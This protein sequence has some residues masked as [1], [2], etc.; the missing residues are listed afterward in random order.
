MSGPSHR[1]RPVPRRDVVPIRRA[2]ISVSDKTGLLELAAALAA[3]GVEI[4][5]TG[6][7]AKTIA[8]CRAS[9]SPRSATLTG[10]PE[11]LDGRVK[12]LHPAVHAG[13]LADLRL[14]SH[15]TEL[16]ELGHRAVRA[17]RVEPLPVRRRRSRR[18]P[19]R[20]RWSSRST[21]AAPRWCARA[22]KNHANVAIVTEPGALRATS[23]TRSPP[24]ARRSPSAARSRSRRSAHTATLRRRR[25][26]LAR[27]ASLAPDDEATGFPAWVGA[28]LDARRACCATARTRTSARRSTR[29]PHGG[30]HR[31]GD[32][33]RRQGDVV[34]QL[35]RC[36][37]GRARRLRPRDARRRDHQAREPVRHRDGATRSPR[38][39]PPRTPATR[40]RRSAA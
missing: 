29:S 31:A 12:T 3:A 8:R 13:L 7:T 21:S 30:G 26:L 11:S 15:E 9:R 2:L 1:P 33:A 39:T 10:F 37:R 22:A 27:A 19:N 36:R 40:S 20:M 38:P 16:A 32:P 14:E 23:S 18:A 6:S 5:S 28:T 17:R 4:V 35:R 34:Q 24:A 25:R